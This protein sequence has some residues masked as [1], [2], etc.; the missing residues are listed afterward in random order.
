[1]TT[2]TP[3]PPVRERLLASADRLFYEHGVHVVGIDWVLADS[4]VSK[5]SLY[6]HFPSK[7]ELV[8][9]YLEGRQ[10]R[11][12]R[13]WAR[14]LEAAGD[15]P[16]ARLLAIFASAA[17]AQAEPGYRGCAFQ[18][19]AAE[20]EAGEAGR[21]VTAAFRAAHLEQLTAIAVDAGVA[22]PEAL[23]R[24]LSLLY[25]GAAAAGYLDA[26][27]IALTDA[28]ALAELAVDAA[29]RPAA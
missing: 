28:R 7:D 20:S 9:A 6:K 24:R 25:D 8:R 26:E 12:A 2:T 21:T 27:S 14:H 29:L 18:R 4:G 19:A 16:R 1:V 17:E 10:E 22:D 15:D 3:R 11:R 5:A 13:R 23:A